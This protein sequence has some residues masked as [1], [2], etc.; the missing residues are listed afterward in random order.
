MMKEEYIQQKIIDLMKK[1]KNKFLVFFLL[2]F[3]NSI[4]G[5]NSISE[6]LVTNVNKPIVYLKETME[7]INGVLISYD[8]LGN[9]DLETEYINGMKNGFSKYYSSNGTLFLKENYFNN[10]KNGEELHYDYNGSG[11]ITQL[12]QYKEG[13][14]TVDGSVDNGVK[15]FDKEG[16]L[17]MVVLN[18]TT[19]YIS[20]CHKERNNGNWKYYM[21]IPDC[22]VPNE[23][24]RGLYM[25]MLSFWVHAYNNMG[26]MMGY[27]NLASLIINEE[28]IKEEDFESDKNFD[29]ID[30]RDEVVFN[31][32]KNFTLIQKVNYIDDHLNRN[33]LD[34]NSD[35]GDCRFVMKY[36]MIFGNSNKSFQ[37]QLNK[38]PFS[39][40]KTG[41]CGNWHTYNYYNDLKINNTSGDLFYEPKDEIITIE[42]AFDKILLAYNGNVNEIVDY[43]FK[44]FDKLI[45]NKYNRR[46][47]G[48]IVIMQDIDL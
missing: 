3:V 24:K 23:M 10:K 19:D 30:F 38:A 40:S 39:L 31:T 12:S 22:V 9:V 36:E 4:F 32:S 33:W 20:F 43:E 11:A 42:V 21:H 25:S 34:N 14:L 13:K 26:S 27:K 17:E 16:N 7:P 45:I 37:Y 41:Y 2:A 28:I 18:I 29:E 15:F 8:S 46:T 1:L 48:T 44:T 47:K 35:C 5:Q 6:D